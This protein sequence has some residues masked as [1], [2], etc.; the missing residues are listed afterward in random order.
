MKRTW[1]LFFFFLFFLFISDPSRAGFTVD[2]GEGS[3]L[4]FIQKYQFWSVYTFSRQRDAAGTPV[5]DRWDSFLRRARLQVQ[6]RIKEPLTYKVS[7]SYDELGKDRYTATPGTGQDENNADFRVW[8]ACVTWAADPAFANITVGY[9]KPQV[10]RESITTA[11]AVESIVKGLTNSYL[12][13]HIVGRPTGRETGVNVGGLLRRGLWSFNYNLGFFDPNHKDIVGEAGGGIRWAPLAAG[14]VAVSF[15]DPEMDHYGMSYRANYFGKRK[16]VTVGMSATRQGRTDLFKKNE[17]VGVDLLSN[18]GNLNVGAECD[19]LGRD[20]GVER[21]TDRV[22]DARAGWNIPLPNGQIIEP[23]FMY[24]EFKGSGNSAKWPGERHSLS[25]L[26][27]NWY[28]DKCIKINLH[29]VWQ[30]DEEDRG[31]F[32]ALGLQLVW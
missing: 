27:V 28:L 19:F 2:F 29:Y 7:L 1:G 18:Y 24:S 6:G 26:G 16:G 17:M 3:T 20:T 11:F 5:D 8:D 12:R 15:G 10:G 25:D 14:R 30:D 32:I 21:Y 4:E 13:R 23:A 9:F 31:D 22:W